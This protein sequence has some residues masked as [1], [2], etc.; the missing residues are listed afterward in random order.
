MTTQTKHYGFNNK[1]FVFEKRKFYLII[2][3]IILTVLLV[4]IPLIF[5]YIKSFT[6]VP[7]NGVGENF[8]FMFSDGYI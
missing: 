5:V 8:N 2:P 6:P 3:F 1:K 4:I 7:G